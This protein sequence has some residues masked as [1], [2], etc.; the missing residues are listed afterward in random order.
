MSLYKKFKTE[1]KVR[2]DD[3]DMF[4]HVHNSKY[5]DYVLAAR[6]EQMDVFYGMSMEEFIKLGYG[7]VVQKVQIEYKR[8]LKMGDIFSVET[9]IVSVHD[10][11][12]KVEFTINNLKTNKTSTVGW[13]DF[14]MIDM[15]TGRSALLPE[16]IIELYSI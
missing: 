11:G 12:C 14:V 16:N 4:N 13:F 10:K 2:P 9:G 5:L 1:H 3:I 8:P 7:W 15:K 6:Y